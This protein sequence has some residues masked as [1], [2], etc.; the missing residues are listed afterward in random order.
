MHIT[1]KAIIKILQN[2]GAKQFM[3]TMVKYFGVRVSQRGLLTKT[4]PIVGGLIGGAWNYAE[5]RF[6]GE[7][8]CQYFEGQELNAG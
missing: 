1:R 5:L 4:V 7:R 3:I 6:V 2:N 8:I